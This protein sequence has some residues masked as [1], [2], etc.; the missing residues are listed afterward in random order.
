MQLYR[1][2][3]ARGEVRGGRFVHGF[4]G[5]QF[6][7]PDALDTARAVRRSEP[8]G[9]ALR[10]AAVDPLNLTGVVTLGPRV[11]AMLGKWVV[12]VDGVPKTS[13]VAA[14]IEDLN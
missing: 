11:P 2:F 3:E 14:V 13:D 7:L 9:E 12:Y 6:A 4:S 1:R 8:T 10:I 5:E